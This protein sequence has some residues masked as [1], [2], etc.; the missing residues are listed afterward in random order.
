MSAVQIDRPTIIRSF[1]DYFFEFLDDML[2]VLPNNKSV[3]TAIRSFRMLADVNKAILI[4]SWYKFVYLK[5]K[6]VI[7][8]GNI[9]F[10]FEKDYSE[11]LTKLSNAN[12]IMEIID[13]VRT[14]AK[15]I[16]ENPKNRDH[17][18][19]YIQTLCKLSE[20]LNNLQE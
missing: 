12:T 19:T 2:K 13:S 1:N 8:D 15:E 16:C 3:L 5:Y 20:I 7:D 9:E 18:A 14:P 17:I 11:D 10:F 6:N 4:K